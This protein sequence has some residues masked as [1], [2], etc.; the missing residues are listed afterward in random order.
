MKIERWVRD[1]FAAFLRRS[2][3]LFGDDV[4]PYL[5]LCRSIMEPV[6]L[7]GSLH[8]KACG[9]LAL[10]LAQRLGQLAAVM[11]NARCQD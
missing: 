8:A 4:A 2:E 9:D 10:G 6:S 7:E 5:L 1:D 3:R 11:E